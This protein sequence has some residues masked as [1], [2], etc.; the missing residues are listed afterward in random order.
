MIFTRLFTQDKSDVYDNLKFKTTSS[1]IKNPDGTI[2]FSAPEIEVPDNYSQVAADVIAQ[3]YFRKAGVPSYLKKVKES[4]VPEWLSRSEPDESKLETIPEDER[5]CAETSAKQVFNRLAGTWTY[6]GWKGGYFSSEKDAKIYY[7][8]MRF[9]L[10]SQM[11]APNSPQWFNTGLHWAYGIDGPSQGHYYVDYKPQ[12]LVKSKSSYVHPQPH[13]CFIQSIKDD[14][15]N[16]GGIMDLWVREARLFKYGSGTGTNFSNLRGNNEELSGGGKSSGMMSFLKIGD[17]AAGA[18]KSGGTTR[19]AAKMV[20]VDVDH[21]DIEEFIDWKVVEEQKVA[22]LVA[23]SKS[24]AKYLGAVMEACNIA[25]YEKDDLYDTKRNKKLKE[26]VLNA[27]SVMIPENYIQRV[28]Q[29]AKQGFKKI[30]FKTYDTDWD[31]EAYL[32]VSGQNSNNSIRV[33]NDFLK[34]VENNN[35]WEL[36]RRTD[37]KVFKKVKAKE[38]WDKI[39]EAA[40]ACADPGLQYD[41]TIN[42]WHTCPQEEKIN[43]SN[44]CSE[45]MFIDDTACNLASL[46]LIKFSKKNKR[47][48]INAFEHAC[49]LW[50]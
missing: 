41:S 12:K 36:I 44:P 22:A 45:Y 20:T 11:G 33:T 48:D 47:L 34:K 21:P 19:R 13:A 23:G 17:R 27:R 38:L 46:N 4:N 26:A 50:T 49:R 15:V 8:E 24:T 40:W 29:F 10:A 1:E 18:I 2:V 31:S 37:G 14:L 7:D 30:E 9:M 39:T 35:D 25:E 6:W 32:T 3:K 16:E 28:I 42:E 43:A 5:F